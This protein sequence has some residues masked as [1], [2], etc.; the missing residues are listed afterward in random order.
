[1]TYLCHIL[2]SH[3]RHMCDANVTSKLSDIKLANQFTFK[4]F[5]GNHLCH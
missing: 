3:L 4:K 2:M 1:M 5:L